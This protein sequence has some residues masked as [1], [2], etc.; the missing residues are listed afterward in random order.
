MGLS[1]V[2]W[3]VTGFDWSA[4]SAAEIVKKVSGWVDSRHKPQ[5]EIVLLHDGG[6]LAFGTDRSFT[7]EA[8]R[9][10]LERY[11]NKQFVTASGLRRDNPEH[12]ALKN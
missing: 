2:M 5:G 3:S 4:K 9:N 6:H 11:A 1:P 10:L 7:V 12:I 8:T